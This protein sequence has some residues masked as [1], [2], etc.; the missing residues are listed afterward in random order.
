VSA[1]G[2]G[3][4]AAVLVLGCGGVKVHR[5]VTGEPG[6]PFGGPVTLHMEGAPLPA[7]YDEVALV[8]AEGG[9]AHLDTLLPA[10]QRQAAALG[11]DAV[12]LVRVDQ[13]SGHASATGV[14]VR[15]RH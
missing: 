6:T 3:L 1:S 14:A 2:V 15:V 10:L 4:L 12:I 11:C 9:G 5:V 8:Q 7:R 13:G